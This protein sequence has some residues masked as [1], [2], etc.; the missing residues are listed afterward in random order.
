MAQ[1]T[2]TRIQFESDFLITA[3]VKPLQPNDAILVACDV[4]GKIPGDYAHLDNGRKKMTA[5]NLL[6]GAA[7]H[8]AQI[9]EKVRTALRNVVGS[10]ADIEV[11]TAATSP[12]KTI[13]WP[14]SKRFQFAAEQAD[15]SFT[16]SYTRK[17][18]TDVQR[19]E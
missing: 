5:G 4:L 19:P 6:R 9:V 16:F 7:R 17:S 12:A 18:D 3:M 10:Q 14:K 11:E 15:G 8:D 1:Q 2:T 13:E